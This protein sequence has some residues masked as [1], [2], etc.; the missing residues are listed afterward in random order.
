MAERFSIVGLAQVVSNNFGL[1]VFSVALASVLYLFVTVESDATS[2]V[3]YPIDYV[4]DD[5][6]VLIGSYPTSIRATLTGPFAPFL[7]YRSTDME[8]IVVDLRGVDA[9]E[10]RQRIDFSDVVT[11]TGL[12]VQ[13]LSPQEFAVTVD[14]RVTREV[15]IV[16]NVVDRPPNGFKISEVRLTPSKIEVEGPESM[17]QTLTFVRTRPIEVSERTETFEVDIELQ[18]LAAPQR[19]RQRETRATV[20]IAEEFVTRTFQVSI[21]VKGPEGVQA[22]VQPP[23][24]SLVL[25]GPM[26]FVNQLTDDSVEAFV[27]ITS[28]I[29]AGERS[30]TKVVELGELPERTGL[31]ELPPKVQVRVR[32]AG[33]RAN[34]AP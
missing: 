12:A 29:E 22:M 6:K 19:L 28:E 11:P 4:P 21:A 15:S 20:V 13:E 32:R 31:T 17:I 30:F 14:N 23:V 26:R 3:E 25:R 9:G 34:P 33:M 27:D 2:E 1:K 7:T 16:D 18:P 24:A 8:P 10:I 5:D